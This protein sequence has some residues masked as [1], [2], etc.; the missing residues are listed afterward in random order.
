MN[1][2]NDLHSLA[3]RLARLAPSHRDPFCFHEEK[4]ELVHELHILAEA[5]AA[6]LGRG[7]ANDNTAGFAPGRYTCKCCDCG[8]RFTG[9]KRSWRCSLCAARS[10]TEK[11]KG[12][13][14][15]L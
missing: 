13:A 15:T 5:I 12:T 1:L 3:N 11:L 14:R 8:E 9:D 2:S 7:A 10:A 4:S 6:A